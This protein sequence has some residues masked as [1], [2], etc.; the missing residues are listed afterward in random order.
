MPLADAAAIARFRRL[1]DET[2]ARVVGQRFSDGDS[3]A[4]A[5][6]TRLGLSLNDYTRSLVVGG[7]EASARRAA[8][9]R[10]RAFAADFAVALERTVESSDS[11]QR[12][13]IA[14]VTGAIVTSPE[15]IRAQVAAPSDP[16]IALTVAYAGALRLIEEDI[17]EAELRL[18]ATVVG[19][20]RAR[21]IA[22]LQP[23]LVR[24]SERAHVIGVALTSV[25]PD[26]LSA[27]ALAAQRIEISQLIDL[28]ALAVRLDQGTP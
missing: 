20:D 5:L 21:T 28:T 7:T 14:L 25:R 19:P 27:D 3:E 18:Q 26:T 4:L 17:A 11:D 12:T 22:D 16:G 6:A 13:A 24:L 15:A 23:P 8:E 9:E 2:L 10:T 1:P